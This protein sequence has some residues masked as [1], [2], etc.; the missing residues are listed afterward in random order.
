MA[1]FKVDPELAAKIEAYVASGRFRDADDVLRYG[2]KLLDEHDSQ[3][4]AFRQS[5]IDADDEIAGTGGIELTPDSFEQMKQ[6]AKGKLLAGRRVG[7]DDW[8]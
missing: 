8:T 1:L 5:L 4:A 7:N 3:V 2:L 6:R